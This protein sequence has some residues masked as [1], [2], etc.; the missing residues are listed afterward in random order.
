M[1]IDASSRRPLLYTV[2]GGLSGPAI[3]P[4]A[5]RIVFD[6]SRSV[7]LPVIAVGGVETVEDVVEFLLA[8]ASA[9]QIGTTLFREP[10]AP[11]R[12]V[13]ELRSYLERAG[14]SDV[15]SLVGAVDLAA[16]KLGPKGSPK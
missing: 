14:V 8:G 6:V 7:G 5:M 4:I 13:R 11:Q 16:T 12:L 9:V 15:T 10:S 2:K 1:A 3:K